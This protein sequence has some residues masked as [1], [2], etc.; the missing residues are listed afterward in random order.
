MQG[1]AAIVVLRIVI[2]SD[3]WAHVES[4]LCAVLGY[5]A[6]HFNKVSV[7]RTLLLKALALYTLVNALVNLVTR[8][9]FGEKVRGKPA[10]RTMMLAS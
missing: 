3:S 5:A 10:Q 2:I 7:D 6:V 8:R 1:R 9:G 4:V